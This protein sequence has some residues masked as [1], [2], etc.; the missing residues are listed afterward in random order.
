M[1]TALVV[2]LSAACTSTPLASGHATPGTSDLTTTIP[3]GVMSAKQACMAVVN[4]RSGGLFTGVE[5]V[6]LVLTTYA[7]G[8][9][10]ES[11]G[12]MS[13]GMPPETLVWVVEVHA[14]EV[15]MARS[16]QPGNQPTGPTPTDYSV[17]MNART[18]QG[19]DSGECDCWPLPLSTVGTLVSLPPTC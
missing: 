2:G 17:V 14:R 9:P 15:Y 11:Q 19:T 8:L 4:Q 6:H 10:V 16:F 3:P 18:G 13:A 12:D 7:K 1:A 5:A